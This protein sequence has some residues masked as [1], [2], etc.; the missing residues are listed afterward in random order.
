MGKSLRIFRTSYVE[1]AWIF[2]GNLTTV[3]IPLPPSSGSRL[4][5]IARRNMW[6]LPAFRP[7]PAFP[8]DCAVVANS[9]D[10]GIH[11][12]TPARERGEPRL[13]PD[14]VSAGRTAHCHQTARSS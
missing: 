12:Q 7:L 14:R 8:D 11:W 3:L 4:L 2:S 13:Q 5:T 6:R 1:A 10:P 9:C